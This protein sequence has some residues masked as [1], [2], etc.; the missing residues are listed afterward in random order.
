MALANGH[1]FIVRARGHVLY[2]EI[3]FIESVVLYSIFVV[4]TKSSAFGTHA[5]RANA[6]DAD[7][8]ESKRREDLTRV[9][10]NIQNVRLVLFSSHKEFEFRAGILAMPDS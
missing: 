4:S 1:L 3:L 10:F 6:G 5:P 2:Y 9:A 7:V 8:S